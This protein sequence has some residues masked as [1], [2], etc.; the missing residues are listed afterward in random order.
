MTSVHGSLKGF[1]EHGNETSN[2]IKAI[3]QVL[4]SQEELRASS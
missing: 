2:S 4:A 1:Y 3:E